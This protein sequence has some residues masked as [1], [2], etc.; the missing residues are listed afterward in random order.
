VFLWDEQL[1]PI[2]G[3]RN[4]VPIF[5][6]TMSMVNKLVSDMNTK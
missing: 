5:G 1:R 6:Q 4:V 3:Q 2:S